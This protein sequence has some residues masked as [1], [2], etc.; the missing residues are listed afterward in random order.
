MVQVVNREVKQWK[1]H[2]DGI[3][4]ILATRGGL[5]SLNAEPYIKHK[6][7]GYVADNRVQ[8]MILI[9]PSFQLFWLY[10]QMSLGTAPEFASYPR[11]PFSPALCIAISKLPEP[12][13]DLALDGC[14][15]TDLITSMAPILSLARKFTIQGHK[16]R[17]DVRRI[18]CLAYDLEELFTVADLT[19]LELL[20]LLALIDYAVTLDAERRQHWLIVGSCQINCARILFTGFNYNP[21]RHDLFLWIGAILTAAGESTLQT[22]KLGQKILSRCK[23]EYPFDR[24]TLLDNCS[25]YAWDSILT[26]KLDSRYD[27][28]SILSPAS[29]PA[30]SS[31]TTD[32]RSQT[33]TPEAYPMIISDKW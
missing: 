10:K 19:Q 16:D 17:E 13:S 25:K 28:N 7:I 1:A 26:E 22:A 4:R 32:S 20:L 27:F 18:K 8:S 11:H 24:S 21:S 5:E 23:K 15:C 29:S 3:E 9:S 2:I 12:L 6:V 33:L 14:L 30:A 31:D